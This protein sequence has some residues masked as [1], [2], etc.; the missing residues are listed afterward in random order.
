MVG[1]MNRD[2][3]VKTLEG[4]YAC[5]YS[6]SR[7][8]MW[9]KGET[10]GHT[11]TVKEIYFDCDRDTLLIMVEQAVAACHKGYRSCFFTKYENGS[12]TVMGDKVFVPQKK[13]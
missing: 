10:S 4:P 8:E 11:Q 7:Q 9:L 2:A 1:Y 6:R 3:V 13:S 12:E 5:F